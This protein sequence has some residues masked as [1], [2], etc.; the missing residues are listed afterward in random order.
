[1]LY[2]YMDSQV[3]AP[4][5]ENSLY[6]LGQG[7][8]DKQPGKREYDGGQSFRVVAVFGLFNEL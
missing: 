7:G 3:L 6:V 2:F 5:I 1:M 8:T 4:H